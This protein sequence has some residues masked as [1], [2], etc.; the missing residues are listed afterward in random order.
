MIHQ[1]KSDKRGKDIQNEK[2]KYRIASVEPLSHKQLLGYCFGERIH[3][4][5]HKAAD[6]K[7]Q[8]KAAYGTI[9]NAEYPYNKSKHQTL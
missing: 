4:I 3:R 1:T 9:G 5:G 8:D 7:K 6:Q 2:K